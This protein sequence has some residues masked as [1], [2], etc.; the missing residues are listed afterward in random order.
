MAG[1]MQVNAQDRRPGNPPQTPP[2]GGAA[3]VTPGANGGQRPATPPAQKGPKPYKEVITEKAKTQKGMF[4]VHQVEDKY[5]LEIPDSLLGRDILVVNRIARA[6]AANG[7]RSGAGYAGDIISES[8]IQFAKGPEDRLFI[9][10][11][12]Y[13]ERATDSVGGMYKSV[14]NSNIQPIVYSFDIKA[15]SKDST[16]SVVEITPLITSDNDLLF[17]DAGDKRA[18]SLGSVQADKSYVVSVHTYPTNINIRTVKTY[19]RAPASPAQSIGGIRFGGAASTDP[20]TYELNNSMVLLPKKPMRARR[21]D[22]RVGYFSSGYVDF[23]AN[24]QGVKTI[25]NIRRWRLEPKPEDVEK[26]K[27]GELVEPAKPIIFY[28][29]PSTPKKWIPYLI[30]GV[31]DWQIAFEKAGFKNAI[32]GK[33]APTKAEDPSWSLEDARY[34]AIVYKPS[35]IANASG[36]HVADPRS[37]EIMESHINWYHNVMRLLRDWYLVQASPSDPGARKMEFDDELMGQLIRFV[38][39]HEVGHTLGLRHNFGSS[40]TVPVEKLRDKA[41]VE[42]NGHTPSIMD[43]A[44]FNYVAQPEDKISQVGLFPRIGDYDKWAIEWGY[45]WFPDTKN[46]EED[47]DQLNKLTVERLKNPRLWWGDGESYGDDPRSQTE[48]LGDNAIKA[49][50]Y[51]VKNLKRILP[52]LAD[53]TRKPGEAY[54]D[55]QTLYNQVTGQFGRYIG[56]VSR[57]IGG[58]ERTPKTAEQ[59]GPVYVFTAKAKQKE[60]MRWIQDNVFKTPTWLIDE[61]YTSLT[62]QSPQSVIS[63]LQSRALSTMFSGNTVSK[64]QRFEAEKPAEAYTLLEMMT[65]LR[66]G[67]FSELAAK[68][69]VDIYRRSLQKDYAERLISIV[70]PQEGPST[71]SLGGITLSTGGSGSANSDLVSVAKAQLRALLAEVKAA[72]PAIADGSTR[73][74]LQDLQDR[75]EKALK[76]D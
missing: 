40:S 19:G 72:Q 34:S 31:N 73:I 50:D 18:Y 55:Y 14:M 57:S 30:Q 8:V 45:R 15:L 29:D 35:D 60:A 24:P 47:R 42:A 32:I 52:Q 53:W 69:P 51:G 11:M 26:Y 6:A 5:Y 39:S 10:K 16:G 43:Y 62:N 65:D 1:M 75:I 58:I 9:N 64:L 56:H 54:E 7:N 68:K 61:K 21:F 28:I 66:K 76:K 48:D 44:R 23:D 25:T 2:A 33:M 17:F 37:G 13:R 74:H 71:I 41:W 27:R 63:S 12:S 4:W 49:S 46:E 67:V 36:P 3:Q 38:S 20:A 59:P 70:T 22:D